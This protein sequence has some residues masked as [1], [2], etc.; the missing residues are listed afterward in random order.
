MS[1]SRHPIAIL[2]WL[3]ALAFCLPATAAIVN[4]QFTVSATS[5]PLDGQ[6][7]DGSFS[8]DDQDQPPA[9]IDGLFPLV[10]FSFDFD[11]TAFALGDLDYGDAVFDSGS[12]IGLEAGN[13]TFSFLP[14]ISPLPPAFL[15]ESVQGPGDGNPSFTQVPEPAGGLLAA[16]AF[17]AMLIGRRRSPSRR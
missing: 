14:A 16:A 10:S 3:V 4:Y 11:G 2:C 5:G 1:R 7:F 12:F 8:F 15:Y 13:S 6:S 9:T 17:G